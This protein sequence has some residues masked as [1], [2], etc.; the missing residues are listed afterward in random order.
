MSPVSGEPATM[1]NPA[2]ASPAR[3][4]DQSAEP[5]HASPEHTPMSTTLMH[6][7]P[8]APS[9]AA[10]PARAEQPRPGRL[11]RATAGALVG[12]WVW[13]AFSE[14]FNPALVSL[15]ELL[16]VPLSE[17]S[18]WEPAAG[19]L[20]LLWVSTLG[21]CSA[22]LLQGTLSLIAAFHPALGLALRRSRVRVSLGSFKIS[23]LDLN[24][25]QGQADALYP[26]YIELR[27]R[28][29]NHRLIK[30]HDGNQEHIGSL[31]PAFD[32]LYGL[33]ATMRQAMRDAGPGGLP[34]LERAE[35]AEADPA[36][37]AIEAIDAKVRPFL[38]RWHP[39]FDQWQK[40]GLP[41]RRWGQ[42]EACRE[43]L[44]LALTEVRAL[45]A[46]LDVVYGVPPSND[47]T[48]THEAGRALLDAMSKHD[49]DTTTPVG[50]GPEI[51]LA[52][53]KLWHQLRAGLLQPGLDAEGVEKLALLAEAALVALPVIPPD[54][55]LRVGERR[56]DDQMLSWCAALRQ[57]QEPDQGFEDWIG[58][59]IEYLGPRPGSTDQGPW[60]AAP[61]VSG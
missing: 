10:Q 35:G 26:L 17:T 54:V 60:S 48:P 43:D 1:K 37:K 13:A 33:F 2:P 4:A 41:E 32:S 18:P 56:P 8:A 50:W 15:G 57:P 39:H 19:A 22:W 28:V 52:Y 59:L 49:P 31:K 6:T 30:E 42:W 27:S 11:R 20:P 40:T 58:G 61:K 55:R 23:G 3:P 36:L 53:V 14:G 47:Q 38:S 45:V 34:L 7:P 5:K 21:A 24:F 16:M 51:D 46:E 12:L 44:D 25:S 9:P 29:T